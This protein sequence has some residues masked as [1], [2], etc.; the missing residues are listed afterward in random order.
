M[1]YTAGQRRTF[2]ALVLV[3][4]LIA[5]VLVLA[6]LDGLW[7]VAFSLLYPV[8]FRMTFVASADF[9]PVSFRQSVAVRR[10]LRRREVVLHYQPKVVLATGQTIAVEGLARWNH[11]RRGVLL[12]GAWLRATE[13]RWLEMR[14]CLY[15]L[16]IAIQQAKAWK[17]D[18]LDIVIQVNVSPRC[19][20]DPSFPRCVDQLLDRWDVPASSIGLEV[21]EATLDLPDRALSIAEQLTGRGIVLSL[22]DFGVGHSSM[23]RLL[24]L[25]F[26]ELKIDKSFVMGMIGSDRH[27]AVV[28]AAISLGHGLGMDIVAEGVEDVATRERLVAMGCDIAQGFLFSRALPANDLVSYVRAH[29]PPTPVLVPA[30]PR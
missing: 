8:A 26:A 29:E 1:R 22:D 9:E 2:F 12:P 14:F 30:A 7:L 6:G 24:R 23:R 20:V 25:P 27:S 10:A 21:T 17:A 3:G 5:V 15:I 19:F 4:A 11:P 18:G 13:T 28:G 16:D